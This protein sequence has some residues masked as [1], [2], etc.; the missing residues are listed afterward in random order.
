[1]QPKNVVKAWV[2]AFNSKDLDALSDFY[3]EDASNHQVAEETA[4]GR[5]AISK[6]LPK[7]ST[8]RRWCASPRIFLK[9]E[10]GQFSSGVIPKVSATCG[11]LHIVD[12]KIVL[13]RGCW[14]KLTFL[15]TNGLS[16][17]EGA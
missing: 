13:Q 1:M 9:M 16:L 14:G 4:R 7:V 5:A 11:F 3:R 15:L 2:E 12:A 6:C 8:R 17:L 10:N